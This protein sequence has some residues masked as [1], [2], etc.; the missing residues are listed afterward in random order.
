MTVTINRLTYLHTIP[1]PPK[2]PVT[3]RYDR[4]VFL[5]AR[6]ADALKHYRPAPMRD[7]D[8]W[9]EAEA[10]EALHIAVWLDPDLSD[11]YRVWLLAREQERRQAERYRIKWCRTLETDDL[12]QILA[13]RL[14]QRVEALKPEQIRGYSGKTLRNLAVNETRQARE[15]NVIQLSTLGDI[16]DQRED[17]ETDVLL[18]D[19]LARALASLPEPERGVYTLIAGGFSQVEVSQC[20]GI[21]YRTVKRRVETARKLL[22]PWRADLLTA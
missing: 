16:Q 20:L 21:P 19:W 11:S 9:T 18:N 6:I 8:P 3:R 4:L 5:R 13:L 17:G 10:R 12:V 2:R 1:A 14:L 15:R 22:E 7:D